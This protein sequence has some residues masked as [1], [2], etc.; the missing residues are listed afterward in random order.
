MLLVCED[1]SELSF[2]F[3][4]DILL[5]F[6]HASVD[7]FDEA[8]GQLDGIDVFLASVISRFNAEESYVGVWWAGRNLCMFLY[9]CV[10]QIISQGTAVK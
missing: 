6:K 3:F 2:R 1:T 5:S 8:S 7:V 9:K 10:S 4:L